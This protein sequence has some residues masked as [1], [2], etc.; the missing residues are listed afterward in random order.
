[1]VSPSI[2]PCTDM[3]SRLGNNCIRRG[4]RFAHHVH[5]RD[6][7]NLTFSVELELHRAF[8]VGVALR[9]KNRV[10]R[11]RAPRGGS[12]RE[13]RRN[14]AMAMCSRARNR[15]RGERENIHRS[16]ESADLVLMLDAESLLFVNGE[17]NLSD[18][19]LFLQVDEPVR[20]DDDLYSALNSSENL[21][22]LLAD[23]VS[24]DERD[25]DPVHWLGTPAARFAACCLANTVVGAITRTRR[26]PCW[27]RTSRA[28][29]L[30]S[31]RNRRRR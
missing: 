16:L 5:S 2:W 30:P 9:S 29:R 28:W 13:M 6:V 26:R 18:V 14:P 24:R 1:M 25:V 4:G 19:I 3:M 27:R 17:S 10:D 12:A 31:S 22:L 11:R 7:V 21:S 20:A 15:R 8:D 23:D